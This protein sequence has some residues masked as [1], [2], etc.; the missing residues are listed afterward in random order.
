MELPNH[1]GVTIVLLLMW[2]FLAITSIFV[3]LTAN[4]HALLKLAQ[5][6][7]LLKSDILLI[8]LLVAGI[9]TFSCIM[10]VKVMCVTMDVMH[11][12][13]NN[14]RCSE[15]VI[16]ASDMLWFLVEIAFY[17]GM[18]FLAVHRL[19]I[20]CSSLVRGKTFCSH[21]L[22]SVIGAATSWFLGIIFVTAATVSAVDVSDGHKPFLQVT[23][24]FFFFLSLITLLMSY[25]KVLMY[26][27]KAGEKMPNELQYRLNYQRFFEMTRA[28]RQ[29]LAHMR[30]QTHHVRGLSICSMLSNSDLL[31]PRPGRVSRVSQTSLGGAL[32][33]ALLGA[34]LDPLNLMFGTKNAA[35][36]VQRHI[37]RGQSSLSV[38]RVMS[39]KRRKVPSI[40]AESSFSLP[41]S[42]D[43]KDDGFGPED[44][45][46]KESVSVPKEIQV[47]Y[48]LSKMNQSGDKS[49]LHWVEQSSDASNSWSSG[50]MRRS[51]PSRN[52]YSLSVPN[53]HRPK[54][55][56][57]SKQSELSTISSVSSLTTPMQST[58]EGSRCGNSLSGR[59]TKCWSFISEEVPSQ[60]PPFVQRASAC[61]LP[62]DSEIHPS[63][64]FPCQTRPVP[65]IHCDGEELNP[66]DDPPNFSFT[67]VLFDEDVHGNEVL[68]QP[69]SMMSEEDRDEDPK[70]HDNCEIISTNDIQQCIRGSS[71]DLGDTSEEDERPWMKG[72]DP[73][74][75]DFSPPKC[76][77]FP[78]SRTSLEL[79]QLPSRKE[80]VQSM[81]RENT[82]KS[83]SNTLN[84]SS[85]SSPSFRIRKISRVCPEGLAHHAPPIK[86][87]VSTDSHTE[88][89]APGTK[90]HSKDSGIGQS[91]LTSEGNSCSS[92]M[93]CISEKKPGHG[94]LSSREMADPKA[95][96]QILPVI[97]EIPSRLQNP[98][99]SKMKSKFCITLKKTLLL[100]AHF[101]LLLLPLSIV[102]IILVCASFSML[103]GDLILILVQATGSFAFSLFPFVYIF[104]NKSLMQS[105]LKT[106]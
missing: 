45:G 59:E 58:S 64:A 31:P 32:A 13:F 84:M 3:G 87:S 68:C 20:I 50:N 76:D 49:F 75:L 96:S 30:Q 9:L 43:D 51:K 66:M 36:G 14:S 27:H 98:F 62:S 17:I 11:E 4:I 95:S 47:G 33:P 35:Q 70:D 61:S 97:S 89:H 67:E 82:K 41:G 18:S 25:G 8:S 52:Q 7:K 53:W 92:R 106:N 105:S 6:V 60:V 44:D 94:N 42:V 102:R 21:F 12:R 85:S 40:I 81:L 2:F 54:L 74:P 104:H 19:R 10:P 101:I 46:R 16:L 103:Y 100:M 1:S 80:S 79:H 48:F 57:L 83:L 63:L 99:S 69:F 34:G 38:K 37:S 26:V 90:C 39:V 5:K 56:I 24:V 88:H 93:S 91:S 72:E 71:A 86:A 77:L 29:S 28:L 65:E 78:S 23:P 15:N 73:S 22:F 55:S